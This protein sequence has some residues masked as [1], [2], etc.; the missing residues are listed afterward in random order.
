MANKT[1]S[2]LYPPMFHV[3]GADVTVDLVLMEPMEKS[4]VPPRGAAQ[5][6]W[7]DRLIR[8]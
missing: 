5:S 4:K 8:L 3:A 6:A 7:N 1:L 2:N